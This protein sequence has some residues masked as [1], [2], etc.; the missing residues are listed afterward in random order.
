MLTKRGFII[1]KKDY[2]NNV[3]NEIRKELTITPKINNTFVK[4]VPSFK[5][6]LEN[7][8]KMSL[9]KYYGINKF[10]NYTIKQYQTKKAKL[11]FSGLLR[12]LQK[13][14]VD[15]V[16]SKLLE[17]KGGLISCQP[18]FGKT[19]IAL[20][21]TFLLQGK[22]L[23]I[24]HKSFLV[25]QWKDRI[26][27]YLPNA[28]I[29]TI[30]QDIIDIHK[31]DIVIGMLQSISMINYDLSIFDDFK[32]CII[33]E[34]HHIS[35]KIFSQALNKINCAKYKIGLSAT[36]KR[37]D[38]CDFVLHYYIGP[39]LYLLEPTKEHKVNVKIF[40]MTYDDK[41]F[42]VVVNKF[43]QKLQL[44][45]METEISK[46][47]ERNKFIVKQLKKLI[48]K[49]PNRHILVLSNRISQL[50][51]LHDLLD[52]DDIAGYYIGGMKQKDLKIS[53]TK[54]IIFASY[55]MAD[56]ALD[57]PILSGV[58]FVSSKKNVKQ[59]LG[60]I[61]RKKMHE[62]ENKPIV[63]DFYN[64][65]NGFHNA[66]KERYKLYKSLK[67]DIEMINVENGVIIAESD[68]EEYDFS[69]DTS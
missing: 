16:Y 47:P 50:K 46:I 1:I 52:M 57:I 54:N 10:P 18:G 21:L 61:L 2:D 38:G 55:A 35:S 9:P 65:L 40:K 6:Y 12:P 26:K 22:T 24:V 66:Y 28:S 56:E 23:V 43:T 33:D 59:A 31:K 11:E 41:R 5:I 42:D 44:S 49:E 62:Y 17:T 27:Q 29:G 51:V 25:N 8:T 69:D 37:E 39:L 13:Q 32:T 14:I 45:T 67:Y 20:Y 48:I 36:P 15:D 30:Q 34:C 68:S 64:D 4:F 7:T 3:L 53:E 60:R 19:V 63:Y 58:F